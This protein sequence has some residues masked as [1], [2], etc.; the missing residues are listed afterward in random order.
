VS[1]EKAKLQGSM[2]GSIPCQRCQ[3]RSHSA[4]LRPRDS[5]PPQPK[6]LRI[7]SER[8]PTECPYKIHFKIV[9]RFVCKTNP[10]CGRVFKDLSYR[11]PLAQPSETTK[12]VTRPTKSGTI[13]SGVCTASSGA[14]VFAPAEARSNVRKVRRDRSYHPALSSDPRVHGPGHGRAGK[15]IDRRA[16]ERKG[17]AASSY[18]ARGPMKIFLAGVRLAGR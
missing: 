8:T 5:R 17:G 14:E 1:E 15:G 16:G 6:P 7:P 2:C 18:L 11:L 3:R 13:R 10:I 12:I 4:P 9:D